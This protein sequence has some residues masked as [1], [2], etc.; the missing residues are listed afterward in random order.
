MEP[1]QLNI[2]ELI[3][4][5]PITK[6]S[7]DYNVK[8]LIKIKSQFTEFEQ[9]LFLS[10]F[11]CYF[12]FHPTNDFI[13]DLDHVWKWLGYTQ[14]NK[15]KHLLEKHFVIDVDYKKPLYD[16]AKR[17]D[18]QVNGGQNK[19]T[20]MLN[21]KT[22][23]LFCIKSDTRKA[24][25][26]HAYFLN[27]E[28]LIQEVI[29]EE[30]SEL[31]VQLKLKNAETEEQAQ[32]LQLQT[33]QLQQQTDQLQLQTHQLNQVDKEKELLKEQTLLEQFPLNTQCIY[34][35]KIDNKSG[36]IPGHKMYHETLIKFGQSNNLAERVKCHKKTYEN[37]RLYA[38]YKVKNKIEIENVM[39]K[40][41]ILKKRLRNIT[42]SEITHRE[43]LALNDTEF[44][45]DKMEDYIKEIIKQNEYNI[46]N[47]NLLVE[48]NAVLEEENYKLKTALEEKKKKNE[49]LAKKLEDY[50]GT[51]T[52]DL[53]VTAKNKIAS[54]YAICK[55][56]YFLYV[57]QY[58]EMRFICSISR[59]KDFEQIQT[60]LKQLYPLGEM[61]YK[62]IVKFPFS[63]KN[64]MFLLKQN[65]TL[66]GNNKF[67]G[68]FVDV[69]QIV[70]IAVR[71][72]KL[73]VEKAADLPHLL[74]ILQNADAMGTKAMGTKAMGSIL[75]PDPETPQV[76]KAKRSID[77]I[78]KETG[79]IVQTY[80]SIE[81]AGRALGLTTGTAI[82]IAL[83]EKRV[84]KDF[85]WR[86]SGFSKEEQFSAQPVFKICC[87]T[88]T[89]MRFNTIADAAKDANISAPALRQ[90]IL[91]H[92]HL[93]DHHWIFNKDVKSTHYS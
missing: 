37:F 30:N 56:G 72:E 54:N 43:L 69:K 89:K 51:N 93:L 62:E 55:Y 92:V 82:G 12:N 49:E 44:S 32:Q 83:R 20:F 2:V 75:I 16:I 61:K 26:I 47:Y 52:Q 18:K 24:N 85:L 84:C 14:K 23:K 6:L 70:D 86:Y 46:E 71:L 38:A 65:L 78:N 59:Q 33:H 19:E 17:S 81:A 53:T 4:N 28:Q 57:Y 80:E 36:G 67:E 27:M 15:A 8:L 66:L 25:E 87:S 91:T 1:N 88:G 45:L 31:K 79:Q 7:K 58:A 40:S 77:Q 42:V 5:N 3:E 64:M 10:S 76:K 74:S 68:A 34:I 29:N 90:R 22:F 41:P 39:K 50:M 9:Q 73:F 60:N 21:V 63:E 11:Y 13:I 48:K 35:G